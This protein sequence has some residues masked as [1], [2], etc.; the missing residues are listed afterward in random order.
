MV[1]TPAFLP[2]AAQNYALA[3]SSFTRAAEMGSADGMVNAGL[4]HLHGLGTSRDVLK[5][6]ALFTRGAHTGSFRCEIANLYP[7][8]RLPSGYGSG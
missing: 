5:A 3:L 4:C 6:F 7:P 1:R 2:R 8:W